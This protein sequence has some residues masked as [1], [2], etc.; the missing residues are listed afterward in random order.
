MCAL[1]FLARGYDRSIPLQYLINA[2]SSLGPTAQVGALKAKNEE[3]ADRLERSTARLDQLAASGL[4]AYPSSMA[5]TRG[6]GASS[7][8]PGEG[9][10][11]SSQFKAVKFNA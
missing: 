2:L 1:S 8:Q 4:L 7:T 11:N 9:T 10:A 3:L 5:G 6:H